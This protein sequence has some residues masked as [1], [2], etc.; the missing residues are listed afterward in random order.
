MPINYLA[1]LVASIVSFII[2]MLWYSPLL[3]GKAWIKLMNFSKEDMNKAKKKG[4]GKTMLLG[5]IATL[6]TAY[7][8]SYFINV[9]RYSSAGDG[10]VLGFMIWLGFLATTL[11]GSVL[12]EGKP[13]ALY[14]LNITYHL[15]NLVI[16]GA[17]LGAWV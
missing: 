6:V 9:L 5:F 4:M 11:L 16:L 17:I 7:V 1:I 3:F 15:V 12:W 14:F 10:A 13:Y 2:G 8:L